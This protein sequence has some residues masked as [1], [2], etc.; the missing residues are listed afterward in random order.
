M[1]GIQKKED[2]FFLLLQE[3]SAKILVVGDAF[4]DLV[5]DYSDVERKVAQLKLLETE[6]DHLTHKILNSLNASF[7]TPFDREDIYDVTK[8][9]DEIVDLLEEVGSRFLIYD[10]RQLRPQCVQFATQ[11]SRCLKELDKLFRH[12]SEIKKND[13]VREQIIEINRLENEGDV[14]FRNTMNELFVNEKDA[15]ELIRWKH[16]FE[17]LENCLDACE[18][19][20][21]TIEGVVMKYA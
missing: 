14:F 2:E 18:A 16:L 1:I 13:V 15:I 3:F 4:E 7:V 19:V 17:E 5:K 10:V 8:G 11:I 6:C 20:A 12:L 21:N 9:L